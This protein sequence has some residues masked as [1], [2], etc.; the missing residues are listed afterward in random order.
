MNT[1]CLCTARGVLALLAL[2]VSS[3]VFVAAYCLEGRAH[4][5]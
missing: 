2:A 4:A 5:H 1:L 3:L